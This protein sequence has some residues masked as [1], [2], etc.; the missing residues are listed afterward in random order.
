MKTM[1]FAAAASLLVL[2]VA[3]QAK[4]IASDDQGGPSRAV[5]AVAKHRPLVTNPL[6]QANP[7][8]LPSYEVR[9]DGLLINGLM[10]AAGWEG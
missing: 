7:T 9:P 2:G 1:I 3:A 8:G 10:P 6:S 5:V 4:Q